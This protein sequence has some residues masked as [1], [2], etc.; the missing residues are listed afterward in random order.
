M[1]HL[2]FEMMDTSD[3]WYD[4]SGDTDTNRLILLIYPCLCYNVIFL[5]RSIW[6]IKCHDGFARSRA[7]YPTM[8]Q[9]DLNLTWWLFTIIVFI[10]AYGWS[11]V[12]IH[13]HSY[14]NCCLEW[15]WLFQNTFLLT[16]SSFNLDESRNLRSRDSGNS[17]FGS[18]LFSPTC[19]RSLSDSWAT[20]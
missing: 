17:R 8:K 16:D 7:K 2:C 9:S 11:L 12:I 5:F 18:G 13:T 4:L 10:T 19:K 15:S 3:E 14:Q 20:N 6:R 1:R